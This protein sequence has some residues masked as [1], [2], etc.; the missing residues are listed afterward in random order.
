MARII[1]EH[2][3]GEDTHKDHRSPTPN[4]NQGL[5]KH[6]P[7]PDSYRQPLLK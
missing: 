3:E 1:K 4:S 2:P 7:P 6:I 5:I